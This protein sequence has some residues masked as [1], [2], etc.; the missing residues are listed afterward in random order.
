ME[1]LKTVK[2]VKIYALSLFFW[3]L[4]M[5]GFFYLIGS[6]KDEIL[7]QILGALEGVLYSFLGLI[8]FFGLWKWIVLINQIFSDKPLK[9]PEEWI[10]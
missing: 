6:N 10:K 8:L 4:L 3:T 1:T 2:T 9:S 5:A 7:D